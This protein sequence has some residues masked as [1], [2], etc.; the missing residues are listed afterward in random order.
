MHEI[1]KKLYSEKLTTRELDIL[2]FEDD[3]S[4]TYDDIYNNSSLDN[5]LDRLELWLKWEDLLHNPKNKDFFK[6]LYDETWITI[7]SDRELTTLRIIAD[8]NWYWLDFNF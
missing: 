6:A 1:R 2:R 3:F 7:T 8:E 4:K 5:F